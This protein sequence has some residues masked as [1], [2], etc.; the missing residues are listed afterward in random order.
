MGRVPDLAIASRRVLTGEGLRPAAVLLAGE[1]ILAVV[2]PEDVPPG[3]P[4]RDFGTSVV[5]PGLVDS[6]VHINEPGRT[7]WEGFWCATRAAAA[8]GVTTLVDM[9]LNSIP[10]TTTPAALRAKQAAAKDRLFV[11][12]GFWGGVVPGNAGELLGLLAEGACGFKAFLVPSGV[13]EFPHVGEADLRLALPILA[14]RGVPLLAH[15]EIA[16]PGP[17]PD[18]DEREYST[19]LATRP[20]SWENEAVRLL[21]RLGQDTEAAIHIVHL[22]SAEATFD[23]EAARE[24]GLCFT[25]E[26]CPHYLALAAEGIPRGRTD[27]KCSPPIRGDENRERLWAALRRG[28]IDMVVSDHSPCSPER[29]GLETGDFLAAWGGIA[30]LQLRLPVVWTEARRR[31]CTIDEM[32]PWLS[33]RPA[34]LA[35]LGGR[36]G[37]LD[38]GHDADLVV[39]DPE[40]SFEVRREDLH[41][42]HTL[43]PYAGLRLEGVV[44]ATFLRGKVVYDRGAFSPRPLGALLRRGPQPG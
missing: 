9:P 15:A 4:C 30:S 2:S 39:W 38:P 22:S 42:R 32:A 28:V 23:I 41:H 5:M 3:C 13:D 25:A 17:D 35:G 34:E 20:S 21:I 14:E 10:P 1:R 31:G 7:E 18:G 12:C 29:K 24:A 33:R 40:A 11:D 16:L 36:K 27:F 44:E 43:T 26:T 8:G 37:R 19:Y 6:H